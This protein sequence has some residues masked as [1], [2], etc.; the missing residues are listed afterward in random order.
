MVYLRL[1]DVWARYSEHE[2]YVL[3]G[4]NL[5][6]EK[7]EILALLG[8]SGCG[9]STTLK[10]IAGFVTPAR[11][12]VFIDGEDVTHIP[13][14]KRNIGIVFQ[15]Y[16][17]FPHMTVF[18]NI[19]YGLKLR[20]LSMSEIRRKVGEVIELVG[21]SGLE[22]KYPKELSGGQQQ[23]IALARALAIGPKI[24]LLDEPMSNIDPILRSRLRGDLKDIL[25]RQNITTVYVTHDRDDAFEIADRIAIMNEGMIE[26]VGTPEQLFNRPETR[27]VAEFVGIENIFKLNYKS[28]VRETDE[29]LVLS[30]TNDAYIVVPR[31]KWEGETIYFG[32]RPERLVLLR[33]KPASPPYIKGRVLVRAFKGIISRYVVGTSMG[34]MIVHAPVEERDINVGDVVYITYDIDDVLL[35]TR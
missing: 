5:E 29:H 21:L 2:S 22:D 24:V 16:A 32:I 20:K 35:F 19:A 1:Q 28:V 8:P 4:I 26:Q 18:Q 6:V 15:S 10:T 9:K 33:E 12:K 23:R 25:K 7:G 14:N 3:K 30:P 17:L 11:G 27:L 31:N 34:N 13:P